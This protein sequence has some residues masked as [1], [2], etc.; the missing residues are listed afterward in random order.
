MSLPQGQPELQIFGNRAGLLCLTNVLLWF[1]AN[2]FRREFLSLGDLPFVQEEGSVS[3]C[4]RLTT[5]DRKGDH[6]VLF[7]T[8][9]DAQLEW[10]ISEHDLQEV[11]LLMHR[12][13]SVPEHEYDRLQMAADTEAGVQV[14]MTDAVEWIQT[15]G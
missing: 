3:V 5:E 12:L 11:A 13:I 8:D 6:G 15:T 2:A 9:K 10:V 14:R 4:I 7:R 1:V